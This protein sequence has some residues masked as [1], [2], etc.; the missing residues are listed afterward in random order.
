MA[1]PVEILKKTLTLD[2]AQKAGLINKLIASLNTPNKEMDELWSKEA[3]SRID[4]CEWGKIK[5]IAL[6]KVLEKYK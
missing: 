4:A 3:E 1:V 6:D 2:S 5:A